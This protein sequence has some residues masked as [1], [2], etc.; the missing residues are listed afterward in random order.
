MKDRPLKYKHTFI[1]LKCVN[2]F[3]N[4][5]IQSKVNTYMIKSDKIY[6]VICNVIAYSKCLVSY[7]HTCFCKIGRNV[8]DGR[9][10]FY[11]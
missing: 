8:G 6:C 5:D 7:M 3:I 1:S 4:K 10:K 11:I 2:S 9:G